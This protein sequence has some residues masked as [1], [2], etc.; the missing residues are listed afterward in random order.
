MS[1]Q[2]QHEWF[3]LEHGSYHLSWLELLLCFFS[4]DALWLG[5]AC[6]KVA[7][8]LACMQFGQVATNERL[9]QAR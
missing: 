9:T 6:S 3:H 5:H 1:K 7:I 8:R 4:R 2:H